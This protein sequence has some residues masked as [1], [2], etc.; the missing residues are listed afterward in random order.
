LRDFKDGSIDRVAG[1]LYQREGPFT[2]TPRI[3]ELIT[4]EIKALIVLPNKALKM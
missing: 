3:E 4:E 1:D 2:Y